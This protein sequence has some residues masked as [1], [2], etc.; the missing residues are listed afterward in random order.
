[1]SQKKNSRGCSF[2]FAEMNKRKNSCK[3]EEKAGGNW[4]YVEKS[5]Y[6][7]TNCWMKDSKGWCYLSSGGVMQKNRAIKDTKGYCLVRVILWT[8]I[9]SP[10]ILK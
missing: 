6:L 4:Y 5:G 3:R 10:D 9:I 8:P 1:M 2:L 7:K